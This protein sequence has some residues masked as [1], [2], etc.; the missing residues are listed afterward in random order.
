MRIK[1]QVSMKLAQY[2]FEL[3]TAASKGNLEAIK[4]IH[5]QDFP[6]DAEGQ[7]SK[8][9]PLHWAALNRASRCG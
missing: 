5:E 3:N 1:G 6:L 9:I 4:S 7:E 8:R 2:F